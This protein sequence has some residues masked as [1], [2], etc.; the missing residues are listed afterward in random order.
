MPQIKTIA[1]QELG[2]PSA[3]PR[4]TVEISPTLLF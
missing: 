2:R 1:I 4:E 3:Y